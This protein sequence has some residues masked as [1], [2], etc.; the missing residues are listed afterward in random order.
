MNAEKIMP[1]VYSRYMK[2]YKR[3]YSFQTNN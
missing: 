2:Y 1:N 3:K